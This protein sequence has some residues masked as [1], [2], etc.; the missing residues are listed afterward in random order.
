MQREVDARGAPAPAVRARLKTGRRRAGSAQRE[1]RLG[2]KPGQLGLV[3]DAQAQPSGR[4]GFPE[5]SGDRDLAVG[6]QRASGQVRARRRRH[7]ADDRI[8]RGAQRERDVRHH[9]VGG[10]RAVEGDLAEITREPQ[11]AHARGRVGQREGRL[12][13]TAAGDLA[14][15]VG[16]QEGVD[17]QRTRRERQDVLDTDPARGHESCRPGARAEMEGAAHLAERIT[18][19]AGELEGRGIEIAGRRVQPRRQVEREHYR[20]RSDDRV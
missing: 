10:R 19:C 15:P 2:V 1:V 11:A 13:G 20:V 8:A 9:A 18:R 7:K 14:V 6:R 17:G 3:R 5:R 16:D 4:P 12:P